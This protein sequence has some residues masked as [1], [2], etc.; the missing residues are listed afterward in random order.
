MVFKLRLESQV[1]PRQNFLA[2]WS[3]STPQPV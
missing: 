2:G 3:R 1:G